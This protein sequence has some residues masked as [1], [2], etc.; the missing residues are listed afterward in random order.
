MCYKEFA[1]INGKDLAYVRTNEWTKDVI[2][3]FHGFMG[4]KEYLPDI[5]YE[6]DICIVSFDR[7]GVGESPIDEYYSME[8]F[9]KNVHD[10]LM[11]HDVKSIK[12]VGHSAGGYYA[13][14]FTQM[15]PEVVQSSSLLSSMVPLNSPK[16][17]RILN[18][19]WKLI[20]FLSLKLKRISKFYFKKMASSINKDYDNQLESNL[21]TL[22]ESER[23]FM[24]ENQELIKNSV[25]NAVSNNGLGVYYDVVIHY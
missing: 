5:E 21:E 2:L 14:V 24:E 1:N 9:L 3:F 17:K 6:N 15:Y 12:V 25:L 23:E 8:S 13:Q 20:S 4:S 11:E 22:F 10:V 16:T 19:E 18:T 7:P